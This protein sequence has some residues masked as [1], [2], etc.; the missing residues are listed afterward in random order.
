MHP[1]AALHLW[2]ALDPPIPGGVFCKPSY[3]CPYYLWRKAYFGVSFDVW[4]IGITLYAMLEGRVFYS[5]ANPS[6]DA[7]FALLWEAET[8][9]A[10]AEAQVLQQAL[11][12]SANLSSHPAFSRAL[13]GISD[14]DGDDLEDEMGLGEK[15]V[16]PPSLKS[17]DSSS[18]IDEERG[19]FVSWKPLPISQQQQ[20]QG[21][22]GAK[23]SRSASVGAVPPL[24][25]HPLL[26]FLRRRSSERAREGREPLSSEVID[27]LVRI[28]RIRPESRPLSAEEVLSHPWFHEVTHSVS[29]SSST[30]SLPSASA[31]SSTSST[32]TAST[33]TEAA[34]TTSALGGFFSNLRVR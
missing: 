21:I 28:L 12:K 3:A 15:P 27:L 20:L 31:S 14:Y 24:R 30:A 19:A 32:S 9:Y 26:A 5:Q 23:V 4:S 16:H 7:Y 11:E 1:P 22:S 29:N 18:S 10:S 13:T 17:T 6:I 25:Q 8:V 2:K 33:T 34:K